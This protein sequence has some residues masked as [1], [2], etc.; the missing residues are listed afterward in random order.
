MHYKKNIGMKKIYIIKTSSFLTGMFNYRVHY[1]IFLRKSSSIY[2]YKGSYL[3]Q[4]ETIILCN[5]EEMRA[6]CIVSKG[7]ARGYNKTYFKSG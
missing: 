3:V 5:N 7:D 4:Y 1:Q 6:S 2:F